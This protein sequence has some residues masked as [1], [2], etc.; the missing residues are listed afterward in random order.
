LNKTAI[1]TVR[2][3]TLSLLALA[4]TFW[5]REALAA[6]S[7][8]AEG[9]QARLR[10][11]SASDAVGRE[12]ALQLGLEFQMRPSWKIYWRSPGDAGLPPEIDWS[13][14][15]NVASS[16]FRWPAP[17]RFTLFGLDTFG[18]EGEVVL[19]LTVRVAEPGQPTELRAHI[20]YLICDPKICVPA[21]A[22]L[23][24]NLPA[25]PTAPSPESELIQRFIEEVP[26]DG[27][28][29]G[30][31][32]LRVAQG[33]TET[34]PKLIVEMAADPAV[35]APDAIV[36]GPESLRFGA[37]EVALSAEGGR[38]RFEI[39][40][41]AVDAG[42]PAL[43]GLPVTLT[44]Y[45]GK[46]ALEARVTVSGGG[47]AAPSLLAVLGLALLGGF[48]LNF[49]PCVLPV[50]A[51][52][53]LG[54]VGQGGRERSAIRLSFL[55]SAAGILAS[56][57]ALAG[58]L[59]ALK[60]AGAAV[61][62]GIQFQQP[63]FLAALSLILVLFAANL[64][65]LFHLP[66]PS[67]LGGTGATEAVGHGH[68]L[69][70]AFAA[71][72]FATLLATPCSAPFLGT[73]VGFALARGT[74][75]I[76]TIFAAL[77]L[78]LAAPWLAVAAVPALARALP[79]PGRWMVWLKAALGLSLLAAALWLISILELQIGRAAALVTAGLLAAVLLVMALRRL[80]PG[81]WRAASPVAVGLLALAALLVPIRLPVVAA[82]PLSAD[83]AE[84]GPWRPFAEEAISGLVASGKTVLV[85]VTADWCLTCQVN[86]ALVLDNAE[87]RPLLAAETT[88]A[89]RA[90]WTRPDPAIAAYL[91][92]FGRYGIPFDVV[93][94]PKAPQGIP[95]PEVLTKEAVRK[96]LA[97][98]GP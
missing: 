86:K 23:A 35:G 6:A 62:W 84:A 14:S 40:V 91:A 51:L 12:A 11:L 4:G 95:L 28:K 37:P 39:P 69:A 43:A 81:R 89:M 21:E 68:S 92:G 52:K 63:V 8:W 80:L 61:G 60:S 59:I 1:L 32:L 29:D 55:A 88:V 42:A 57:L 13:G 71:G 75:E 66:V 90:D 83:P 78:G 67:W 49:M 5:G 64:F 22:K 3:L 50:L 76:L 36:E 48:I 16:E 10:L 24:L 46:R 38:A 93:Y 72:A 96:A 31:R 15:R 17:H 73:A 53:L 54:V 47:S 82:P 7:D 65:G 79:R 97:A 98:A 70:G 25:G 26:G 87:I 19:P 45:D 56:F 34:E 58:A 30:L 85:D 74:T 2:L 18:Y 20:R 94:G 44:V 27:A 41:Q 33:G 9:D 77:G